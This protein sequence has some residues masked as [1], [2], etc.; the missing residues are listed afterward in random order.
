MSNDFKLSKCLSPTSILNKRTGK[1]VIVS[2]GKCKA[3]LMDR[4]NKDSLL[5]SLHELDY[6][7]SAFITLTYSDDNIPLLQIDDVGDTLV[8]YN[9]CHRFK[10]KVGECINID[11]KDKYKNYK[12]FIDKCNFKH[13]GDNLVPYTNI[14]DCQLFLKR[15]RKF[16]TKYTDEKITY[17]A[18][19]EY[20]PVHFRPHIHLLL[21][22]NTE[23]TLHTYIEIVQKAWTFGRVDASLSRNK[24]KQYVA[25]YVNSYSSLP[26]ILR[27][28]STKPKKV[29]STNLAK[30]FYTSQKEKIYEDAFSQVSRR[31]ECINGKVVSIKPWRSLNYTL[32]PKCRGYADKSASELYDTYTILLPL[33][34][35]YGLWKVSEIAFELVYDIIYRS[36]DLY[37]NK[38]LNF[39]RHEYIEFRYNNPQSDIKDVINFFKSILYLSSHFITNV[40]DNR[41]ELFYLRI[42]QIRKYY[43][44][45]EYFSLS[46]DLS[47]SETLCK[48]NYTWEYV[49]YKYDKYVYLPSFKKLP[50][51]QKYLRHVDEYFENSV[52]HKKLNDLNNLFTNG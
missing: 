40:C 17:F 21:F 47:D 15:F 7:Y 16:L 10:Y 18:V 51:Y 14:Y 36:P 37:T 46:N 4:C 49:K 9:L 25:K 1:R 2:C 12:S 13:L 38:Y 23:Q 24:C 41:Q 39:F 6:K 43:S 44:D 11:L 30:C 20:G 8:L 42:K 45:A 31:S 32:F 48:K 22:F 35:Y 33:R 26:K 52:K 5:L 28:R 27:N 34:Q 50:E 29:H 3:C 19:T